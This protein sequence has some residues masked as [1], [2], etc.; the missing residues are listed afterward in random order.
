MTHKQTQRRT[1]ILIT[2]TMT[3]MLLSFTST[4]TVAGLTRNQTNDNTIAF[5]GKN[6]HITK[7]KYSKNLNQL[8]FVDIEVIPSK[9][10]YKV[11]EPMEFS[12]KGK[13]DFYLSVFNTTDN[14]KELLFP[15]IK[16]KS[17]FFYAGKTYTIP[18]NV[19]F[20]SN[21]VG[22]EKILFIAT[23]KRLR[24]GANALG[25][26]IMLSENASEMNN[27]DYYTLEDV[28]AEISNY[29]QKHDT[30]TTGKLTNPE[31]KLLKIKVYR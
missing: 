28:L 4:A 20:Y 5:V 11:R 19:D 26:T 18:R 31:P 13:S 14:S 3:A 15:N 7:Q 25:D 27:L 2:I 9:R 1:S 23:E 6:V 16:T 24:L 22:E 12:I 21:K 10:A 30:K 17:D 29:N 8:K